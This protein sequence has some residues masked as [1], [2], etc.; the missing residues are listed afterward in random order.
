M[1]AAYLKARRQKM[2]AL[3]SGM[4]DGIS[5]DELKFAFVDKV[6]N[7]NAGNLTAASEELGVCLKTMNN[8]VRNEPTTCK[9]LTRDN[10]LRNPKI[11]LICP[12]C[13]HDSS[14]S[15]WSKYID[16]MLCCPYCNK[17]S[18]KKDIEVK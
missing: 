4:P 11:I 15:K 8:W 1:A 14:I 10:K 17:Y 12:K 6:V 18:S 16:Q 7:C 13:K 2:I 9:V 5:L 3:L